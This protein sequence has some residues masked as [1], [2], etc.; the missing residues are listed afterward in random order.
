MIAPRSIAILAPMA[1]VRK[2]LLFDPDAQPSCWN[3]RM[4][5]GEYAVLYSSYQLVLPDDSEDLPSGPFCTVFSTLAE[6]EEYAA[7]KVRDY[8]SLRCRIYDDQGLGRQPIREIRGTEHKG[9]SEISSRFRRWFGGT[10]LFGGI[11]L[12]ILDW[13]TGFSLTWPAT[14]GTR[15]IPVGLIL[16]VME[17]GIAL[18]AKHKKHSKKQDGR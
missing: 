18:S 13:S 12:T 6:A 3:E 1:Q 16:L 7:Q 14:I 2:L 11:V 10:L 9:E 8:P 4:V 15:M 17:V 5:P